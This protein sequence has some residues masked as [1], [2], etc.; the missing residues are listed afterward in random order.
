MDTIF[1]LFFL[2]ISGTGLCLRNV[3]SNENR[4]TA[5]VKKVNNFIVS[6]VSHYI[7]WSLS[8]LIITSDPFEILIYPVINA[9]NEDAVM[10]C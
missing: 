6:E 9:R 8:K 7:L 2:N 4:T 3:V 1:V 10:W 5:N